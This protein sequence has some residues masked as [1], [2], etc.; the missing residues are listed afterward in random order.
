MAK[1]KRGRKSKSP[2]KRIITDLLRQEKPKPRGLRGFVREYIRQLRRYLIT[3]L[4]V[5]VPL[6]VTL[7]LSWWVLSTVGF[8]I[9]GMIRDLVL[10]ANTLGEIYGQ[11][12]PSLRVLTAFQYRFGLG[13]LL[14]ILLFLTTGFLTRYIVGR[15]VITLLERIVSMIPGIN[16][17]YVA[18]QQIRDVFVTRDGTVFQEVVLFEYPRPGIYA[19][20]FVTARD[21]GIIQK[22][23]GKPLIA[24]F[25]PTTPNPTS[26]YLLYL[27]PEDLTRLDITLEE[28]M[29]LIISG[30]AYLPNQNRLA[31]PPVAEGGQK[32]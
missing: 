13:F 29:K 3:G 23:L 1:N 5:W 24:V 8:G 4:L 9:E 6:I 32:P 12:F 19:V 28:A 18:V 27:P 10:R 14:A 22:N 21:Q 7:W 16:R 17:V 25:L 26:G 2:Q 15:R 20:G 30:G 31:G 11:R